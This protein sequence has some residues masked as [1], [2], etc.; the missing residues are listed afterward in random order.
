MFSGGCASQYP[1][2]SPSFNDPMTESL[3][4]FAA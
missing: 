1:I 2:C 3:P 4:D